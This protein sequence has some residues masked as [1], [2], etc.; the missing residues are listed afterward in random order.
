MGYALPWRCEDGGGKRSE[1]RAISMASSMM[2]DESYCRFSSSRLM[3]SMA[4]EARQNNCCRAMPM[5]T[6]TTG[7]HDVIVI[8]FSCTSYAFLDVIHISNLILG[9]CISANLHL[10]HTQR[11]ITSGSNHLSKRYEKSE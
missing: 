2:S 4:R 5:M 10:H 9:D 1:G 11:F 7:K 3:V 8:S 6:M